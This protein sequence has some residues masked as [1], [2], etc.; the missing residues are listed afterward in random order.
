M[1]GDLKLFKKQYTVRTLIKKEIHDGQIR[2]KAVF[3]GEDLE[4]RL[5]QIQFRKDR[6]WTLWMNSLPEILHL[7]LTLIVL[8]HTQINLDAGLL[9]KETYQSKIQVKK[10]LM[11]AFQ[12]SEQ[13]ILIIIEIRRRK[14][15]DP[16]AAE[17]GR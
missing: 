17:S 8:R 6:I 12:N 10:A 15:G 3:R 4:I 9:D 2:L 7:R 13:F 1:I 11:T 5:F 14:S 16:I